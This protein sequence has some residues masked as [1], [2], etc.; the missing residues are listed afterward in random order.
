LP[1]ARI[2][3][4]ASAIMTDQSSDQLQS[5]HEPHV[6][7][8]HVISIETCVPFITKDGSSIRELLSHRNSAIENQSLA[9]ATIL[10]GCITERHVHKLTEEIYY[11]VSGTGQMMIGDFVRQVAVGDAI[12]IPP[13][14]VHQIHNNGTQELKLLCCCSPPYEHSDTYLTPTE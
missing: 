3:W 11:I 4:L 12:P 14:Q 8:L 10:P 7:N 6:A 9:E 5:T 1:D 13:G 2:C